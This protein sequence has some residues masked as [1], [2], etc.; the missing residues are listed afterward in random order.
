M[1]AGQ[2]GLLHATTGSGKTYA[3]WF[4]ALARAAALG[5]PLRGRGRRRSACSGSRRCARSRPTSP[6][7]CARRCDELGAAV[8]VGLR[9]GDT[10]PAER[11]RQDRRFPTALVTTPESLSLM[12]TRDDARDE[13][14]GVHTV[15]VDEWH[16]LM[17]NKRG[18]Q[19]QLALARLRRWNPGLVVWGLSATLGNLRGGDAGAARRGERGRAGARPHR[20]ERSSSTRCPARPGPLLLGRPPRRADAAAGGGRRSSA[21]ATTLVFTNMRSQA[22]IWYQLLLRSAARVGRADRAAPRLARQGECANG[23]STG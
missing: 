10:P 11:A 5:V 23:S 17:G 19:V 18:V 4:G 1:A 12:L 14:R 8:D 9:T 2:S 7:R 3:V 21:R 15:I 20:Q 13:L 6:R 16:E 22:E